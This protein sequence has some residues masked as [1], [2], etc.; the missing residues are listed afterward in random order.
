MRNFYKNCEYDI[1]VYKTKDMKHSKQIIT[2]NSKIGICV[3]L[4]SLLQSC[5]ES[6]L[7]TEKE[8]QEMVDTIAE[9]RKTGVKNRV[10]FSNWEAE[11]E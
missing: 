6:K 2:G 3:G 8:L 1:Q 10:I 5:I 7:I 9:A 4:S 11:N